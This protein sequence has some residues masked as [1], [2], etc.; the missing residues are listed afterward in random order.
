[1]RARVLHSP[2]SIMPCI[3]HIP[4]LLPPREALAAGGIAPQVPH[5]ASLLARARTTRQPEWDDSAS[6]CQVF[7]ITRQQDWPLAPLLAHQAGLPAAQGYWLCAT[8]VHLETRRNALVLSGTAALD[9]SGAESAALA[10]ALA[11]HL[12]ED[13]VTLHQAGPAQWLLQIGAAPAMTTTSL[14]RARG[15][16]VRELLPQGADSRRWHRLLTEMQ[17]LLHAHA[18]NGARE[19]AAQR[20][21]NSVWLWGGGTLPAAPA[22]AV[23]MVWSDDDVVRA[24]GHHA[25]SRIA[26]PPARIVPGT[27]AGG[28]HL[29]VNRLLAEPL[30]RGDLPAWRA[31]LCTLDR[32]W[33]Q[34]L[35]AALQC[36]RLDRLGIITDDGDDARRFDIRPADLYKFWRKNKYL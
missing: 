13:G 31:A 2:A 15:R 36:R 1:M 9:I 34:P 33:F 7:G 20:P 21:L 19:A 3:L 8:P 12:R 5:L 23:S 10:A 35:L 29:L 4:G 24:L 17:M 30:R 32:D 27:V 28:T 6:L 18:V 25:G 26:P 16:D 22:A 14:E 11:A